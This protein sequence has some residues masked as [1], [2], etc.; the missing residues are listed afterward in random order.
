MASDVS[1]L[2]HKI[3]ADGDHPLSDKL[4][5]IKFAQKCV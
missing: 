2:D 1:Y 4:E 5:A 3:N